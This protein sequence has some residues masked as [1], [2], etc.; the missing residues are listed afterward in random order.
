MPL[1]DLEKRLQTLI[2]IHLEKLLPNPLLREQIG[3]KFASAIRTNIHTQSLQNSNYSVPSNFYLV[4]NPSKAAD[5]EKNPRILDELT[6][7]LI[8]VTDEMGI[9]FEVPPSLTLVTDAN[10]DVD[11]FDVRTKPQ[12]NVAETQGISQELDDSQPQSAFLIIGGKRVFQ[13]DEPVTNIGRRLDN[14]LVL[15]DP[16]I[17]RYH[18]QIRLQK[19]RFV[20]F[21]LNST[22]GT[23]VNSIKTSQSILYPGDVISLAGLALVFGQES[24]SKIS[25]K[26][27]TT[28]LVLNPADAASPRKTKPLPPKDPAK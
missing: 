14:H 3:Q 5:W 17:S 28:P 11:F 12:N 6:R 23:F 13:L 15:D 19:N 10:K 9:K 25:R 8:Y 22:G 27:D 18:A 2:E 20:I 21:D 26:G 24:Q 1:I 4:V 7:I 16:R